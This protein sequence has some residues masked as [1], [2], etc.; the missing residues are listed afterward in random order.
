MEE[1]EYWQIA[2]G[3]GSIDLP[4]IFTELNVALL[5]PGQFGDFFDNKKN[6]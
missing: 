2:A 6:L 1:R 5:G 3:D 4:K